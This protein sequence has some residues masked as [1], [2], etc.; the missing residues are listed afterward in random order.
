M[1]PR[2]LT[3]LWRIPRSSSRSTACAKV[4]W[5][6]A[7]AR[8]C[9]Q[10]GSVAVR[11]GSASRD[12]SVKTVIS[13]PSPGSKYRWLSP[14]LSRFGCSNTN[15]M[16][17]TPSQKSIDVRRSAPTIVMWCT[18]WL[19]SL[20]M[21]TSR[22][23]F[24]ELG[25]VLAPLQRAPRQQLDLRLDDQHA[26][27][28]RGD[29]VRQRRIGRD[30]SRQLHGHRQRRLLLHARRPRPDHDVAADPGREPG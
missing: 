9:T 4:T 2:S 20:R 7:N 12:S 13:R 26:A 24:D 28:P 5:E 6:T 15:G 14:G 22:S 16:P 29:R 10:P 21:E 11:V 19:W 17:S 30:V 1:N 18:P 23:A 25:L 8:W 3:P 27:H